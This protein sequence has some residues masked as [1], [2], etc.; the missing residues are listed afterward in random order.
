MVG[1]RRDMYYIGIDLGTSA[2]KL[3]L[4][5][6]RGGIANVVSKSYPVAYPHPGWSEQNPEDWW[7][8][9]REGVPELLAAPGVDASQVRGI[10]CGGQMHGL[11]ALDAQDEVIRPCIL[12]NDGRT[13]DQVRYLNEE[14]G[15]NR[16]SALTGN[17][18]FAGFTAPKLLWLREHEPENFARI[19][20]IMLPK[21]YITYRLTGAFVTDVSDAS[22]ML[23]LDVEHRC[24]SK[25]MLDIC[26]MAEGQLP[27]LHES[28]EAVGTVRPEV[29]ASLGLPAGVTVAAGAGDNAAAAVGCCAVGTGTCNI[30]LGTSGTVFIPSEHFRVDPVNALHA[31]DHADGT[32]HLMGCILAAAS[33]SG[34]F[35][36][37]ILRAED[38]DAEE[39]AIAP[40]P[41]PTDLPYFLP[42]LMGE[43]S[44][45][46]DAAARAAF[47]GIRADTSR[48]DLVRAVREGVAF[49][50][51]DCVEVARTQGIAPDHSTLCGGGAKSAFMR[52]LMAD[53][54]NMRLDLPETE[55][56]P[57]YG[58]AML[59]AVA[60][61]D[62]PSV[63]ACAADL[64]RIRSSVKPRPDHV[65]AEE[66]RY[67][68]WRELYP[69]LKPIYH[70]L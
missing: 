38:F 26:G 31:F 50:I 64:V 43:R 40:E 17:I 11:V 5:D 42:Y 19:A 22:G 27:V 33:C 4:M 66:R 20:K 57:G 46:N 58:G 70:Q 47:I 15:R 30:S 6:E 10:G 59:A 56:G 1:E 61:G 62:W 51:R 21:D 44:P 25:E 13:E 35:V 9:V 41:A 32:Y 28:Y 48:A 54:L 53:V 45:H 39:V 29:A 18:A 65:A 14:I 2:V 52:Q 8:A 69:A 24:W 67:R 12:W 68:I 37:D 7:R 63:Q 49:A 55:Q 16:L 36:G 34:W 3:L 23:L 60:C